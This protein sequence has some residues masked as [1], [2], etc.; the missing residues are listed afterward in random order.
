MN[1]SALRC[2]WETFQAELSKIPSENWDIV[3]EKLWSSQAPP[4][5]ANFLKE[6]PTKRRRLLEPAASFFR[7]AP[8]EATALLPYAPEDLDCL[9]CRESLLVAA[10]AQPPRSCSNGHLLCQ[11]CFE[12]VGMLGGK[13]PMCKTSLRGSPTVPIIRKLAQSAPSLCS[14]GCGD[15]LFGALREKHLQSECMLRKVVCPQCSEKPVYQDFFGH[16]E[17][18]YKAQTLALNGSWSGTLREQED[19]DKGYLSWRDQLIRFGG[20]FLRLNHVRLE[21]K[22]HSEKLLTINVTSYGPKDGV[23]TLQAEC[24][25]KSSEHVISSCRAQLPTGCSR[26]IVMNVL[27]PYGFKDV[28]LCLRTA[29]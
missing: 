16:L 27:L 3:I 28:G 14:N 23:I 7:G 21:S 24:K 20:A 10:L 5:L 12:R 1:D 22:E 15:V 25:A 2:A 26:D 17:E 6:T 18:H 13:C 11:S 29:P 19:L 8:S 9:V 4:V